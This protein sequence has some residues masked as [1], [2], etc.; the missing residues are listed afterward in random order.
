M[1]IDPRFF[2]LSTST[3][4]ALAQLTGC[5]L[6]GDGDRPVTDA[7]PV[8]MAGD[9]DLT[10]L[11]GAQGADDMAGLAGAVIVTTA[12]LC[13]ALPDGTVCLVSDAPRRDFATALASLVAERQGVWR[14][15]PGDG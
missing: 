15:H 8:S 10:F 5:E 11:S 6:S 12:D 1:A 9:G 4:A 7:A 13:S 3:A 14:Q 2:S